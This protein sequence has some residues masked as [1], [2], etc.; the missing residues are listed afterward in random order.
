MLY[1]LSYGHHTGERALFY[2]F[3][4]SFRQE[5]KTQPTD[6]NHRF[7]PKRL[8]FGLVGHQLDL[9]FVALDAAFAESGQSCRRQS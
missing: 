5:N 6:S 1:Q 3:S 4:T 9:E 2:R 8:L 7:E